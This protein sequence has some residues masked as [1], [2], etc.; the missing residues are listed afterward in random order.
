MIWVL[1]GYGWYSTP[2]II[3]TFCNLTIL[4]KFVYTFIILVSDPGKVKRDNKIERYIKN[5]RKDLAN[6][7]APMGLGTPPLRAN[8]DYNTK[9]LYAKYETFSYIFM[10]PI[11]AKNAG[12]YYLFFLNELIF[13][14]LYALCLAFNIGE[15]WESAVIKLSIVSLIYIFYIYRMYFDHK[16]IYLSMRSNITISE[17]MTCHK[18]PV[19]LSPDSTYYNPFDKGF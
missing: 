12:A 3:W 15:L 17:R 16:R 10:K 5:N 1:Y 6:I 2:H 4:L 18:N 19:F 11:A 7:K 8:F 9:N 14:L 13:C